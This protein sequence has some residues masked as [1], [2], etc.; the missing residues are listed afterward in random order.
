M[1]VL[2]TDTGKTWII[3]FPNDVVARRTNVEIESPV[4]VMMMGIAD[5]RTLDSRESKAR[6]N[7]S[8]CMKTPLAEIA[9]PASLH[10][11]YQYYFQSLNVD[12]H[13]KEVSRHLIRRE[14][15]SPGS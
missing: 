4:D 10:F 5:A 2:W 12:P 14:S 9:I 13:T 1:P 7:G 3:E 6:A 15:W 8:I 11:T